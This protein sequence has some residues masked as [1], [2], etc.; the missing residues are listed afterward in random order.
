MSWGD[1][2]EALERAFTLTPDDFGVI[3]QAR[4]QP[5]RLERALLL[6]WMRVERTLVSDVATLPPPV[7]AYVARQLE[8]T[9]DVLHGYRHHQQTRTDAVAAIRDYLGVRPLTAQDEERLRDLLAAKVAHTG[10]TAALVQAAED[11]LIQEDRLRPTGETTI[12]RLVYAVRARAEEALFARIAA[13]LT[14]AQRKQ[15]DAL[16]QTEGR[17]SALAGFVTAPRT[18]SVQA[19]TAECERLQRMRAVQVEP[20]DWGDITLNRLRQW[21]AIVRRLSAQALRRCSE[22]KR[23]TVLLAFLVV[24]CEEITNIIVEMFDTLIGRTFDHSDE[25]VATTKAQRAQLLH[26]SARH[27]RKMYDILID[28]AIPDE[29]VRSALFRYLPRER[30]VAQN[31]LYDAFERGEVEVL[32]SLLGRRFSHVR[33]FAPTVLRT[34]QLSSPREDHPLLAGLATLSALEGKTGRAS[35]VPDDA[36]LSFVPPKWKAAVQRQG[37]IHR[38]AWEMTLLH[39][40]RGALRSGDLTVVGS[41]RYAAWDSD[42][43]ARAAWAERRSAWYAETGV[44]ED[45]AVYLAQ[46]KDE[47]HTLTRDVAR[48]MPRNTTVRVEHER[49][50]I[51]VLERVEVPPEVERTRSDLLSHLPQPGLPDVLLEVDRWTHF[52]DAFFHLTSRRPRRRIW[53]TRCARC[54]SPP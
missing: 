34:L 5:H 28:E 23:Y 44:P 43:Y 21:A 30:W 27:L 9:P 2:R 7:I 45:G 50:H 25:G 26:D 36:P 42:L 49:L 18:A 8:L 39:E 35:Q 41:R 54:F 31:T 52:S 46:L 19:I 40:V 17:V 48:R 29:R 53:C 37:S 10:H 15:L 47:L 4:G 11:W 38:Q 24:R 3:L 12:E 13:Q 32:F 16:C 33:A 1:D 20:L 6:S 51:D 14:P 22:A